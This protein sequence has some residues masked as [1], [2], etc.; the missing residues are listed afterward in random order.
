MLEAPSPWS[1]GR[2]NRSGLDCLKDSLWGDSP[3]WR[4]YHEAKRVF[5]AMLIHTGGHRALFYT[6]GAQLARSR[7]RVPPV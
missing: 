4:S 3:D 1:P 6:L 7:D 5:E 2:W